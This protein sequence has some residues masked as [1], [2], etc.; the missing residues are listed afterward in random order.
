M[1]QINNKTMKTNNIISDF[2]PL[3]T[4]PIVAKICKLEA[5]HKNMRLALKEAEL[6]LLSITQAYVDAKRE[7]NLVHG[8]NE[9]VTL[10]PVVVN[11][12]DAIA[13]ARA[14]IN[15]TETENSA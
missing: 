3:D 9:D 7:L 4:Q 13:M 8:F 2:T 15:Q 12:M 1:G 14:V 10:F 6:Q 5:E 11:S